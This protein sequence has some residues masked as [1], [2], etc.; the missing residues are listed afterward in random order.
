M[1]PTRRI[2][3]SGGDKFRDEKS[4]AFDGTDDG[5]NTGLVPTNYTNITISAWVKITNDTDLKPICASRSATDDGFLF[6]VDANEIPTIKING[7]SISG[8]SIAQGVWTHVAFTWDGS[9]IKLYQDGILRNNADESSTMD[10]IKTIEIGK[11][12]SNSYY[13]NGNISEV[14]IYNTTFSA[15][16]IQQIY[17]GREPYNHKEGIVGWWALKAWYRMGDGVNDTFEYINNEVTGYSLEANLVQ[18]NDA[19]F[20]GSG[21]WVSAG[22]TNCAVTPDHD[23]EDVGH[24]STLRIEAGSVSTDRAELPQ[25]ALSS[26]LT[27]GQVYL[28]TFWYKHED[29]TDRTGDGY[30]TIGNTLKQNILRT[31][32]GWTYYK[33]YFVATDSSTNIRVYV[34][35]DNGHENNETLIDAFSIQKVGTNAG[36]SLNMDAN[37]MT[38]DTP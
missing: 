21:N 26:T 19:N 11:E 12:S 7:V 1:F 36:A 15:N 18:G 30:I 33:S 4:L 27:A 28:V 9:V 8:G 29:I 16:S 32:S 6:Y 17:N 37:D 20:E 31:A 3:T 5:L 38:G 2:T 22:A 14:A 24:A 25:S 13:Y 23:S 34:N 35:A 10:T